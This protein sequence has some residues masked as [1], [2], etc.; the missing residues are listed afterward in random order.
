MADDW[1]VT[2][3]LHDEGQAQRAIR[4]LRDRKL[5][6]DVRRRLAQRVAV[7]ADSS[8]MFLYAATGEAAREAE[9]VVRAVLA[10]QQLPVSE[11][12]CPRIVRR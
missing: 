2:A 5:Q 4:S 7:S 10:G 12:A 8:H 9:R 1:R 11:V 3:T 6:D